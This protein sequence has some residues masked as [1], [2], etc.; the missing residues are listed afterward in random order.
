MI[1]AKQCYDALKSNIPQMVA[2]AEAALKAKQVRPHYLD[3]EKSNPKAFVEWLRKVDLGV[4]TPVAGATGARAGGS[5]NIQKVREACAKA[6]KTALVDTFMDTRKQIL[7]ILKKD[8]IQIECQ[9]A[10]KATASLPA[11]GNP[12]TAAK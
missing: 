1:T 6:G 2:G 7:E 4:T 3:P 10:W 12:A 9:V 11:S 5:G 8:K